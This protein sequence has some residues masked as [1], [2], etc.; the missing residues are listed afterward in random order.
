ML[1]PLSEVELNEVDRRTLAAE[2]TSDAEPVTVDARTMRR[3]L[4]ELEKL[5]RRARPDG[6]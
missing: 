4:D 2:R 1:E 5:R 6:A 3:L